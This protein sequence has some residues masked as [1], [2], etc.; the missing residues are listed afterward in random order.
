MA[1]QDQTMT[2]MVQRVRDDG[3][4]FMINMNDNSEQ[5][6]KLGQ[7]A[8]G[9][10][11]RGDT[12]RI[13]YNVSSPK[14]GY[15]QYGDTYWCNSWTNT[16]GATPTS[17]PYEQ[18]AQE[19]EREVGAVVRSAA[20]TLRDDADAMRRFDTNGSIAMQ[21][22]IKAVTEALIANLG[23]VGHNP[24]ADPLGFLIT[25]AAIATD[26]ELLY[27]TIFVHGGR[28]ADAI[29]G[30]RDIVREDGTMDDAPL[31]EDTGP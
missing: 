2:A 3:T 5:W 4:G 26:A 31:P 17:Q 19:L 22:C 30:E 24:Q 29:T 6:F 13:T 8:V 7:S 15:E 23:A 12:V 28:V 16:I 10:P 20:A 11:I 14:R 25:P 1:K 9:C 27:E 21:V 18:K